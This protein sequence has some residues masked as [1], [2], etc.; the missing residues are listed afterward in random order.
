M[1]LTLR[2]YQSFET[3]VRFYSE[4]TYSLRKSADKHQ[5][6][7]ITSNA[8]KYLFSTFSHSNPNIEL[9]EYFP[10]FGQ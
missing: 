6:V 7:I 1:N 4:V 5:T 2:Q 8:Y 10:N 3:N 9:F